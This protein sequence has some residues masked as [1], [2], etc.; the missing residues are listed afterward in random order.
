[1]VVAAR[2]PDGQAE[3]R[4]AHDVDLLVD[5][6]H[7]QLGLVLFGQHLRAHHQQAGGR[8]AVEHLPLGHSFGRHEVAGELFGGELVERF[9]LV[10]GADDPVAITPRV[11]HHFVLVLPVRVG[12]ARHVEPPPPPSLAIARRREQTLHEASGRVRCAVRLEGFDLARSGGQPGEIVRD[13]ADEGAPVGGRGRDESVFGELRR[14]EAV[15]RVLG[16][17][18]VAGPG[19]RPDRADRLEGPVVRLLVRLRSGPCLDG[20]GLRFREHRPL[21]D[22]RGEIG[23]DA[24]RQAAFRRHL[25]VRI[26][27]ADGLDEQALLRGSGHD[28]GP[29]VAAREQSRAGIRAKAA[30]QLLAISGMALE[31]VLGEDGPDALLEELRRLRPRRAARDE[32]GGSQERRCP[33]DRMA[34]SHHR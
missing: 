2:A 29:G 4:A 23:H 3:E 9:V 28:G 14:D 24:V 10:E 12:V 18:I 31:A 34:V 11:G 25:E 20:S 16:V 8:P 33:A 19:G 22:P 21:V 32:S 26:A 17:G 30:L 7:H 13:A 6:V 5:E 15:D 1:M 27:I